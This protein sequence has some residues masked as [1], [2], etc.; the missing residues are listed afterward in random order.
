MNKIPKKFKSTDSHEQ[1]FS[2]N[3]IIPNNFILE[4]KNKTLI[5]SKNNI[6]Q[7]IKLND[8]I[9]IQL[10]EGSSNFN[11]NISETKN[12]TNK[13]LKTLFGTQKA[14]LKNFIKGLQQKYKL[15]LQVI[16]IGFKIELI[17]SKIYLKVGKSHQHIINVPNHIQ[18]ILVDSTC[19]IGYSSD[20]NLLTEFLAKIK[21]MKPVDPYKG[22]GI[23][24]D[25][26]KFILQKEGKKNKK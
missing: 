24:L 7:S 8:L 19:I 10:A 6:T 20:W 23:L 2:K 3:F 12:I 18:I 5:F 15:K 4:V 11:I 16:G 25:N 1:I 14:L 9:N 22:K 13:Q 26:D 21:R 17:N